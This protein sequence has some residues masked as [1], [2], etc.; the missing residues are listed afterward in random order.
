MQ[1]VFNIFNDTDKVWL[2]W[3]EFKGSYL[4]EKLTDYVKNTMNGQSRIYWENKYERDF[5][6]NNK[7]KEV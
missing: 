5:S 7:L 3:D 4:A 2:D 1:L 6:F